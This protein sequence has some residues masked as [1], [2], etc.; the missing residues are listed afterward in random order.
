MIRRTLGEWV[1]DR[2]DGPPGVYAVYEASTTVPLYIGST[3]RG[4]S[5][6]LRRHRRDGGSQT[7]CC[8]LSGY[9]RRSWPVSASWPVEVW[10]PDEIGAKYAPLSKKRVT[11]RQAEIL[12]QRRLHPRLCVSEQEPVPA[13][14]I[15]LWS[16]PT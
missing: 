2:S 4:V 16:L 12:M 10:Q 8:K 6:R 7:R 11:L 14:Q 1:A 5:W 3:A 15:G 13:Q 9:L